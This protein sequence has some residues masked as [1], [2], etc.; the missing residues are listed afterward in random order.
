[1]KKAEELQTSSG[2]VWEDLGTEI[3]IKGNGT[4][5]KKATERNEEILYLIK[6]HPTIESGS[7]SQLF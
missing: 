2:L 4:R 6:M 3:E 7:F 1:M 5:V